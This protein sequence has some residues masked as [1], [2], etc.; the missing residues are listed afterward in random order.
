MSEL[1]LD[2]IFNSDDA[3]ILDE[4]VKA[5]K[6]TSA[7][8]LVRSFQEITEF[9]REHERIPSATTRDI[10]ERKLGAR[11]VGM[12]ANDAKRE[13]LAEHDEFDLLALPEAPTSIDDL[14]GSDDLDILDDDSGLHDVS[15]L[16][17]RAQINDPHEVAQRVK[18]DDFARFEPLFAQ[19]HAEISR[20]EMKLVPFPGVTHIVEGAFFVLGGVMA[21][22]A[23]VREPEI[24]GSGKTKER[25][26]CI[27]DNGTE[28]SLYR[29]S[30]ASRLYETGG[31][32]VAPTSYDTILAD[33]VQ[34]GYIYVLRSLSDDPQ[35]A[36]VADLHKI[37]FSR[38]S[39]E[40]RIANA[41]NEPTY[42]MAPVEVVASYRLYN[43]KASALEHLLHRVF[44]QARL[45]IGQVGKDGRSYA[46]AEWF[47]APLPVIDQAVD[48]IQSGE[49]VDYVYDRERRTL[50]LAEG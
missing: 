8:R 19:K 14:L 11:L 46:P 15:A 32:I 38:G 24:S 39:V 34:S 37:G 36:E 6:V 18:S 10:A 49:I 42:L 22:V 23:E 50:R 44:G 20:G 27:F 41:V 7:D 43:L 4:P 45:D 35:I 25:I 33:D 17:T 28:S 1:S 13:A 9:Y 3:A 48:L 30:L 2:D 40:K 29:Q 16:P 12:L 47:S 26:R 31:F 21:F 5:A